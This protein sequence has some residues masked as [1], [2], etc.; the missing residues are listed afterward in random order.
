MIPLHVVDN[1]AVSV[2]LAAFMTI[3]V[4]LASASAVYVVRQLRPGHK[5]WRGEE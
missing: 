5:Q 4:A 3:S 1:G 2:I